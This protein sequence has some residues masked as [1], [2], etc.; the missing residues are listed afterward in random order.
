MSPQT[1]RI[2][3]SISAAQRTV[4][5]LSNSQTDFH[6]H[7]TTNSPQ[8]ASSTKYS[9]KTVEP[10]ICLSSKSVTRPPQDAAFNPP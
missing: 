7:A 10:L 3:F 1:L 4:P 6:R 8:P 5:V 9:G 2:G